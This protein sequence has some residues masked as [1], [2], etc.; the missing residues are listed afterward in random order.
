[1]HLRP[2]TAVEGLGGVAERL[3]LDG[4]VGCP[5]TEARWPPECQDRTQGETTVE[6]DSWSAGSDGFVFSRTLR[7]WPTSGRPI[8]TRSVRPGRA[9]DGRWTVDAW[10]LL[11]G[12][13]V[14]GGLRLEF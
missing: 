14:N 5:P 12:R 2:V 4:T 10:A 1:M 11:V 6:W 8:G 3:E 13:V 9:A 7:I